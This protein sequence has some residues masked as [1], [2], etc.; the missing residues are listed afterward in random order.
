MELDDLIQPV[1]AT[2]ADF[3]TFVRGLRRSLDEE[4]EI[5]SNITLPAFLDA[6]AAWTEDMAD[7]RSA[8][9]T[10]LPEHPTWH[11]LAIM[12]LSAQIYE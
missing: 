2:R 11:L 8:K 1:V 9:G 10:P 12:L 7:Y 6:L 5:W 4:P 3:V